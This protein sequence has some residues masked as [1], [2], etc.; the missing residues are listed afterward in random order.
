MPHSMNGS[1]DGGVNGAGN[2]GGSGAADRAGV[3][4][5]CTRS[6]SAWLAAVGS[7]ATV[8]WRSAS[9]DVLEPHSNSRMRESYNSVGFTF[10]SNLKFPVLRLQ[11]PRRAGRRATASQRPWGRRC[12]RAGPCWTPT[13]LCKPCACCTLMSPDASGRLLRACLLPSASA[14]GLPCQHLTLPLGATDAAMCCSIL[15]HTWH[16]KPCKRAVKLLCRCN[17]PLV[18]SRDGRLFCVGCDMEVVR[19]G[20]RAATTGAEAAAT[21][22]LSRWPA[23]LTS[24]ILHDS[25]GSAARADGFVEIVADA[26]R[27]VFRRCRCRAAGCSSCA[28][29]TA[30]CCAQCGRPCPRQR[31]PRGH[32]SCAAGDVRVSCSA[33]AGCRHTCHAKRSRLSP[34]CHPFDCSSST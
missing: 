31:Q 22:S 26:R 23:R 12:C 21:N 29:H 30:A 1:L 28:A 15:V 2:G 16:P 20:G 5:T 27:F 13:A 24:H 32:R 14:T 11:L 8:F 9:H 10:L 7:C 18:R 6:D 34:R 4:H 17:T 33:V 25:A 3:T 19:Q